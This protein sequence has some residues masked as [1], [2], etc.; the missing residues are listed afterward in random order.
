MLLAVNVLPASAAGTYDASV[1]VRYVDVDTR[2]S[3]GQVQ[4]YD[5]KLYRGAEGDVSVGNQGA[6][7]LFDLA[8]KDIGSAEEN[9]SLNIDYKST[10]K[11]S[12][13]WSNMHHRLN[14]RGAGLIASNVYTTNP[15]AVNYLAPDQNLMIRRT[16]SELNFGVFAP[17]NSA[18]WFSLRYWSAEKYGRTPFH[19]YQYV[20]G[21]ANVDSTIQ[22]I[23]LGLGTDVGHS[24]AMAVD[25][26]RTDTKDSAYVSSAPYVRGSSFGFLKPNYGQQIMTGAE[27]RFR[28]DPSQKLA[29]TGAFTGRQR[30]NLLNAYKN[31]IVVGALNAAYRAGSKL[32]LVARLYLRANENE[33]NIGYV[34]P[35]G[36]VGASDALKQVNTSQIDKTALKAELG[37]TY[38][39]IERVTLK[40]NYKLEFTH[41]RDAPT[42]DLA[43]T[44]RYWFDGTIT[45]DSDSSN[46]AARQD[47]KHTA[48]VAA[49][50]D[51]PLG[52]EAEGSFK[53][54][55]ANRS[56]FVNQPTWQ[57]DANAGL[58]V[59]LPAQVELTLLGGYLQERNKDNPDRRYSGTRNTYRAALDWAAS[60]RTFV[61]TD[62][63][64]EIINT[65]FNGRFGS[66]TAA[67]GPGTA[68]YESGMT[69]TQRNTVLG[70]HARFNLPKGVV[71][72]GRGSY[73]WSRVQTPLHFN[74]TTAVP[75]TIDD[76]S[77]SDVRI[78]RGSVG[79]EYTP[80]RLKDLTARA[81]Y[82]VDDWVDKTD[83]NNSGRAS[84]AELGVAMK[85]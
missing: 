16:E 70:A 26:V 73:T 27:F 19:A 17:E 65:R 35:R 12:A 5:G 71:L 29:L 8:V 83:V 41:R 59:P 49:K 48:A 84:V 74:S 3:R 21:P 80:E 2:G 31:N 9:A 62:A 66:G 44:D 43:A 45:Y 50:V 13:L 58:T 57:N 14:E 77:P 42:E 85:F 46:S 79:V 81:G 51:L 18:Q 55:Q 82:R 40:G 30:E 78:A 47:T 38:R 76:Y 20:T 1:G 56:A 25:L 61:G 22:D 32:S 33:E 6:G 75:Y 7:G 60:H 53:R 69:N 10:M 64:Y 52:I 63:S 36:T 4:E 37:A 11:L 23:R 67:P 68:F 72:R 54:L 24:A 39:P 28:C 15:L 34:S